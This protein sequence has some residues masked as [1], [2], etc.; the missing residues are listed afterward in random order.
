MA[1]QRFR[2]W[3]FLVAAALLDLALPVQAARTVVIDTQALRVEGVGDSQV[4]VMPE[5][6]A[7]SEEYTLSGAS[8]RFE[9]ASE[10]FL[11]TGAPDRPASLE[12]S[13]ESPFTVTATRSI[14]IV[15]QDESLRAEGEVSYQSPDVQA[16]S[17]LLLVDRRD[18]LEA[19]IEELLS[20]LPPGETREIVVGFFG[21]VGESDRLIV[22]QHDVRVD[23]EDS[24]LE[25]DWVV[26]SEENPDDFI[27]VAAP[28][29]PLRL[30]VVIESED[31]QDENE[32]AGESLP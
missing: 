18:R 17:D 32:R 9:S 3:L 27:S 2:P 7:H 5:F 30:S 28:G 21:R 26:F 8:G 1:N 29:K 20:A 14:T 24:F 16:Q 13:G 10:T 22:M 25:A 12:R 4:I 15:F 6:T 23:R 11:A 19:L 31:G